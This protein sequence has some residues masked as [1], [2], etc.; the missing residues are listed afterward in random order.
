L[1]HDASDR[2]N[3][4]MDEWMNEWNGSEKNESQPA[5]LVCILLM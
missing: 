2:K 5:A 3:E 4:W 1:F